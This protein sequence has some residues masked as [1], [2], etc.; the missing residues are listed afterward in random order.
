MIFSLCYLELQH[1]KMY[2]FIHHNQGWSLCCEARVRRL[3]TP[4]AFI[5]AAAS[6]PGLTPTSC[7]RPAPNSETRSVRNSFTKTKSKFKVDNH[8]N[9]KEKYYFH[10]Y[11]T[12]SG[13]DS[14]DPAWDPDPEAGRDL[15]RPG[16]GRCDSGRRAP[17]VTV[18]SVLVTLYIFYWTIITNKISDNRAV[19]QFVI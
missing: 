3:V 17:A 14:S 13:S 15:A 2:T 12:I 10:F 5:P 8:R 18:Y 7:P 6:T 1:Y 4:S 16:R 9:T 11:F 19:I